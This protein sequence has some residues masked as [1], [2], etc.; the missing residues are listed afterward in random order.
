[1]NEPASCKSW[2][3][4]SKGPALLVR[5]QLPQR[6]TVVKAQLRFWAG[7]LVNLSCKLLEHTHTPPERLGSEQV[8]RRLEAGLYQSVTPSQ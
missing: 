5:N 8:T 1:M 7:W 6:A 2:G 3:P 4:V